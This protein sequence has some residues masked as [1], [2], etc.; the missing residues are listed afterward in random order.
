MP[1]VAIAKRLKIT[2]AR[3]SMIAAVLGASVVL[4]V[5]LSFMIRFV[6]TM[7][8]N[9]QVMSEE[10]K[11]LQT[12]SDT[13]KNIGVCK[14]PKGN[15]YSD[16]ELKNCNPNSLS[17]DAVPNTLRS[18]IINNLA[19]NK[20]LN[21]VSRE[22]DSCKNPATNK[23]WTTEE[24]DMLYDSATTEEE[25]LYANNLMRTCSALRVIPDAL[26]AYK[27][28]SA[29]LAS[30]NQLFILA[31]WQPD[32]IS[33]NDTPSDYKIDG[34][35]SLMVNLAVEAESK[36]VLNVLDKIERSIREYNFEKATIEWG[37]D[38]LIL[39]AKMASYY[40]DKS[41]LIELRKTV[42]GKDK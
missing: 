6:D 5:A 8:F 25:L 7:V 9:A 35:E 36:V 34:L 1:E 19:L 13:I 18:E 38:G 11:A 22:T 3:S 10:G 29:L 21:A 31:D 41:E 30:L 20:N 40:V 4:G 27:N 26:P 15:T 39:T 32:S 37:R 12:Y 28:E 24:L 17:V 23:S 14:K 16:T 2:N 42:K 33:G